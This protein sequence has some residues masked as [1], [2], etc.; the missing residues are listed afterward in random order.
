MT[1]TNGR[2]WGGLGG[3]IQEG[4]YKYLRHMVR[5]E[6]GCMRRLTESQAAVSKLN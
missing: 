3:V 4:E 5:G 6:A 1:R 2:A